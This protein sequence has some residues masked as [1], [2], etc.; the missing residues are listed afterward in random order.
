MF[1]CS[2][3]VCVSGGAIGVM[4]G[5]RKRK[6]Q[7]RGCEHYED[8]DEKQRGSKVLPGGEGVVV[9]EFV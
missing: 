8:K 6:G 2:L 9:R 7:Q 1:M 3:C 5:R 4:R